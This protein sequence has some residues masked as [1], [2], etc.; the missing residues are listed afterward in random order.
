[1]RVLHSNAP[2]FRKTLDVS[3]GLFLHRQT[4]EAF[5]FKYASPCS[6]SFYIYTMYVGKLMTKIQWFPGGRLLVRY[7]SREQPTSRWSLLA[8]L[9][10]A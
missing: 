2:V 4:D 1:M 6:S 7:P 9:W 5:I 10:K 8:L 3:Y